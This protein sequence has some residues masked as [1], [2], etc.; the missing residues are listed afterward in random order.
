MQNIGFAAWLVIT[1]AAAALGNVATGTSIKDWYPSL[2]KP[3]LTPPDWVFGPVWTAIYVMMAIAAWLVWRQ[4]GFAN[5][6]GPLLLYLTQLTLNA[7]WSVLF[8]G[9]K[10]PRLA[11]AEIV[12]LWI[13]ILATLISFRRRSIGAAL[14]LAPYLAWVTFAAVLSFQIA[15]LNR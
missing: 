5:A 9:L 11:A 8:F 7:I 12:V 10:N 14:L 3:A 1:F 13:A 6:R 2:V 4:A 15:N